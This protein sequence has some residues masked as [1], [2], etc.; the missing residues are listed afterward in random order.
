MNCWP[1]Y[2]LYSDDPEAAAHLATFAGRIDTTKR[3]PAA[4]LAVIVGTG[5][6]YVRPDGIHV[7][8]IGALGP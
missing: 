8:P 3:G 4:V 2:R 7:I 5:Y 6:G 1:F